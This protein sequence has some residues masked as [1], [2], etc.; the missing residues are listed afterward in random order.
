LLQLPELPLPQP[1]QQVQQRVPRLELQQEPLPALPVEQQLLAQ[2]R[3]VLRVVLQVEVVHQVPVVD[4]EPVLRLVP[5]QAQTPTEHKAT[6]AVAGFPLS[7]LSTMNMMS[8]AS[9]GVT[10]WPY[11]RNRFTQ[12]LTR[13]LRQQQL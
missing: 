8:M 3:V 11:G 7:M 10:T 9:A 12:C 5:L 4:Q 13:F 6:I 2:A 1:R